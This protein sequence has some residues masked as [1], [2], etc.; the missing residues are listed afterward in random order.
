M[1]VT[2]YG[3]PTCPYCHMARDFLKKKGITFKDI[4]VAGDPKAANEM[5]KLS[6]QMGVPVIVVDGEMI[7]GFDQPAIERA[8]AGKSKGGPAGDVYR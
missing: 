4:D 2:L 5:I 7:I 6:G 1:N 3:T 8:L